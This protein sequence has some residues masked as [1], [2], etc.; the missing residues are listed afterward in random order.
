MSKTLLILS[1]AEVAIVL[2]VAFGYV[3]WRWLRL[4]K[5]AG[6]VFAH[7][8]E[9]RHTLE[10]AV[11]GLS[12]VGRSGGEDIKLRLEFLDG[13]LQVF[14]LDPGEGTAAL[15]P[16]IERSVKLFDRIQQEHAKALMR[17]QLVEEIPALQQESGYPVTVMHQEQFD[18]EDTVASPAI[19]KLTP[20]PNENYQAM[21][22][23]VAEQD[24]KLQHLQ[25]YK[26]A[27]LELSGKFQRVNVANRKLTEYVR[28]F[29][30][31]DERLHPLLQLL[32]KFQH[33]GEEMDM[34]VA[35]VERQRHQT[36]PKMT[37]LMAANQQLAQALS[38][39]R[40][41]IDRVLDERLALQE[42]AQEL[43]AK[44]EIRNKSYSR[45]HS[46]F[47]ALRREYIMLYERHS[48]TMAQNRG[49]ITN[50]LR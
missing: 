38:L 4:R 44:L 10:S 45:L 31:Q 19:E 8:E 6:G 12:L 5:R 37:S 49:P 14:K 13:M 24:Q 34:A 9:T 50:K 16:A 1:L 43:E 26:Q 33:S 3:L 2:L 40:K 7:W 22:A 17:Q 29:A 32:D 48:G 27:V 15:K 46:K 35:E 21:I 20:L 41:Q 23:L 28:S 39:Y 47:E 30:A 25:E 36:E 11:S 42:R 18:L